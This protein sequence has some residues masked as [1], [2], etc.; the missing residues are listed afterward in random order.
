MP[1]NMYK[2]QILWTLNPKT[3]KLNN[4]TVSKP[5]IKTLFTCH[6]IRE[7]DKTPTALSSET[8]WRATDAFSASSSRL[9]IRKNPSRDSSW[10]PFFYGFDEGP[11]W[12]YLSPHH[13][14]HWFSLLVFSSFWICS[15][16]FDCRDRSFSCACCGLFGNRCLIDWRWW[17]AGIRVRELE[18]LRI[19]GRLGLEEEE[20]QRLNVVWMPLQEERERERTIQGLRKTLLCYCYCNN[21]SHARSVQKF[22]TWLNNN[23]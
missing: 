3:L 23:T 22:K 15:W 2:Y 18:I 4:I 1:A 9:P 10:A 8:A 17:S 19:F 21:G 12:D 7:E 14:P 11:C 13:P 6:V 16:W 20:E 5:N